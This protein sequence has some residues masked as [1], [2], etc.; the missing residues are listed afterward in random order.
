MFNSGPSGLFF[1]SLPLLRQHF[2]YLCHTTR[3]T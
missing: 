1:A 2:S 3:F